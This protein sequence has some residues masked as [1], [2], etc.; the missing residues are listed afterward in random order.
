ML[1]QIAKRVLRA[2]LAERVELPRAR[3]ELLAAPG[4]SNA[5]RALLEKV[6]LRLDS[7]EEMYRPFCAAH[8]LNVGLSALRCI[9]SALQAAQPAPEVKSIL[10][11]PCG[12]GR[13]MRFL[14]LRFPA[15]SIFAT[16][17][18]E[19]G[20]NFCRRAF[21]AKPLSTCSDF[22]ALNFE[23]RF[24][25]IWC[26]SL[27]TH[28]DEAAATALLRLFCRHLNPN[29]LCLFTTHGR[30]PAENLETGAFGYGLPPE[31]RAPI[32]AEYREKGY[33]FAT[34]ANQTRY[35]I[36]LVTRERIRAIASGSGA[37]KE[38]FYGERGWDN[39]QDVHAYQR[40]AE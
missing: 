30:Y 25:L 28:I 8:Y 9:E 32:V 20:L 38:L 11:F 19:T 12:H 13:V 40:S 18:D 14:R 34:Y 39:H 24:D 3:R 26:G 16:E 5:E 17:L 23:T 7:R 29:G 4:I 1:R 6:S 37:W 36:S 31:S 2:V 35:G 27:M 15:A 21:D 22:D 33:G 10:D